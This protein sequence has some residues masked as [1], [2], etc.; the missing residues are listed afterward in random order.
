MCISVN[1]MKMS[2]YEEH[3]VESMAQM[4]PLLFLAQMPPPM[5]IYKFSLLS[6]CDS[7]DR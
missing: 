2:R 5:H 3:I 1:Y 7:I 6:D 4:P